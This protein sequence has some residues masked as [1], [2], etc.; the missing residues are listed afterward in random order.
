MV[1]SG[2]I[3]L[4]ASLLFLSP[5]LSPWGVFG[6]SL[7][8]TLTAYT[9]IPTTSTTTPFTRPLPIHFSSPL[10]FPELWPCICK[11]FINGY[12]WT[13]PKDTSKQGPKLLSSVSDLLLYLNRVITSTHPV[14][15]EPFQGV[16]FD[17]FLSFTHTVASFSNSGQLLSKPVPLDKFMLSPRLSCF[18][19]GLSALLVFLNSSLY[20]QWE[21]VLRH[22]FDHGISLLKFFWWLLAGPQS[23]SLSDLCFFLASSLWR[24]TFTLQP[25]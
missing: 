20:C 12:L 25:V 13:S 14:T 21:T 11:I 5:L 8:P 3:S 17:S 16:I 7:N 10:L 2:L 4:R 22:R 18:L 15:P 9:V 19:R 24:L 23:P 1:L 6:G